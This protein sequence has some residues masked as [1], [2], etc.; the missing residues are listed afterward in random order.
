MSACS[1][2]VDSSQIP[3]WLLEDWTQSASPNGQVVSHPVSHLVP[4]A[5]CL[6]LVPWNLSFIHPFVASHSIR[7][8][9]N[10]L[11]S[12]EKRRMELADKG[13]LFSNMTPNESACACC[14]IESK[15]YEILFT[16]VGCTRS[17]CKVC[18][19][20]ILGEYA[21]ATGLV[22]LQAWYC[23]LCVRFNPQAKET[24]KSSRKDQFVLLSLVSF[25]QAKSWDTP[26][27]LVPL[28]CRS[29]ER[30][31]LEFAFYNIA[32]PDERA[33]E[34]YESNF[35]KYCLWLNER[36]ALQ[37]EQQ[38]QYSQGKRKSENSKSNGIPKKENVE[39][40]NALCFWCKEPEATITCS[41]PKCSKTYHRECI[42]S[43]VVEGSDWI[44]PWHA[45][46]TCGAVESNENILK[47][48]RTCPVSFCVSHVPA[49]GGNEVDETYYYDQHTILCPRCTP[50]V[51]RPR[52][53]AKSCDYSNSTVGK[54]MDDNI[55]TDYHKH[56]SHHE[57]SKEWKR[58]R[59]DK[60]REEPS[61]WTG[62]NLREHRSKMSKTQ[63]N[64]SV[65]NHSIEEQDVMP[66]SRRASR[67]SD[68]VNS[69]IVRLVAERSHVSVDMEKMKEYIQQDIDD[70]GI[71]GP[72]RL[73]A[74]YVLKKA[75]RPLTTS[76]IAERMV[77][78]GLWLPTGA[79][80]VNTIAGLLSSDSKKAKEKN[81]SYIYF[82]RLGPSLFVYNP[83]GRG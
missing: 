50:F 70:L 62:M 31:A 34:R 39:R 53:R 77:L 2:S 55:R 8:C 61:E 30:K 11:E 21:V 22:Q 42:M 23:P 52:R 54:Y 20:R 80:P 44:C 28:N 18:V 66:S 36:E 43:D 45:C 75:G 56:T 6:S 38:N 65:V 14:C 48:C 72:C 32:G 19:T 9:R 4:C 5:I 49:D 26:K 78:E 13:L 83:R 47:K 37:L 57:T 1:T 67:K 69:R 17:Y 41:F 60:T 24:L 59:V 82:D 64:S 73:A 35:Q 15:E 71:S 40:Y 81:G 76:E 29:L 16:C 51:E 12:I 27:E 33:L 68:D 79:T 10:C 74:L 7:L 25:A 63:S 58:S 46:L 3:K